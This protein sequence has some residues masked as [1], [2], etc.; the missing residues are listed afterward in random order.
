MRWRGY[1]APTTA[2]G[3]LP[4]TWRGRY[5]SAAAQ[6]EATAGEE[7]TTVTADGERV[8]PGGE[9]EAP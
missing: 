6:E 1:T 7:G 2:C 5:T 9:Q 4:V 3:S 8:G